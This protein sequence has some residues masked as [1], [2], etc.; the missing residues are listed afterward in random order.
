VGINFHKLKKKWQVVD[1][2]FRGLWN[3][4]RSSFIFDFIFGVLTPFSAVF[5]LYQGDQ[6]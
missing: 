6:F 3:P 1:T 2:Q 5:Q 4:I